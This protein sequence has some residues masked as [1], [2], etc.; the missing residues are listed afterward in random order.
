MQFSKTNQSYIDNRYVTNKNNNCEQRSVL[1]YGDI[2]RKPREVRQKLVKRQGSYSDVVLTLAGLQCSN[3]IETAHCHCC[4]I[5]VST[6]KLDTEPMDIHAKR[7][8]TC[9]FVLSRISHKKTNT[10]DKQSY[11]LCEDE[12]IKQ[13]RQRTFSHWPH[14]LSP[15]SSEM[16]EA[17]FFS[18]NI[19][20]RVICIY[21]NIICQ[22]WT[23]NSDTPCEIHRTLSPKCPYVT[24]ML[25]RSQT[26]A[27]LVINEQFGTDQ[28]LASSRADLL[29]SNAI[30][31]AG[32][33][34]SA[35]L[36]MPRRYASFETWSI[37]DSPSVDDLVRAGF[38]YTG[39]EN[40]VTCFYCNGSLQNW[41]PNDNPTIEHARWFPYC[42]YAE[43]LCGVELYRKIR[44]ATR[45]QQEKARANDATNGSS[46]NF[47]NSS[48]G[49]LLIPDESTLS[50]FVTARLDLPISQRLLN[51]NFKLSI[52]KRCW[53]DQFRLKHD[54]FASESDLLMAC[55][56]L[57]KQIKHI[58]GKKENILV[59]CIAMGNIR[60][61]EQL[62]AHDGGELAPQQLIN[63]LP[64]ASELEMNSSS[65]ATNIEEICI[66]TAGIMS[67][68][69]ID[70]ID[71]A[72]KE[73]SEIIERNSASI[74]DPC[75]LRLGSN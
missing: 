64:T 49:R 45:V 53:E 36:E 23:R 18:C 44:E 30:V 70:N 62:E 71:L 48:K 8:P 35:Y 27:I 43:Q 47:A 9:P 42:A 21:C 26:T 38:F 25:A 14:Q 13:V 1:D 29:R 37:T 2:I 59:P 17:G 68:D 75:V 73:I 60:E 52:I 31:H 61:T 16:V 4:G 67:N 22:Q 46:M 54:D 34:N 63:T 20:D 11:A 7:S 3:D 12:T 40:I 50:R 74:H 15:T 10:V 19:S 32:A 39:N 58:G 55:I 33:Y 66:E 51:R 41:A 28:S 57:Q 6:L 24:A 56:I 72:L 69:D 5:Q 65:S